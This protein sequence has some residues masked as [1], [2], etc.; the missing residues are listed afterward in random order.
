MKN[1]LSF[2]S[3][4]L[5]SIMV[6]VICVGLAAG[7]GLYIREA[8]SWKCPC[9]V[10]ALAVRAVGVTLT[11]Y[12]QTWIAWTYVLL[13]NN[14]AAL[15]A[16]ISGNTQ[17]NQESDSYETMVAARTR[18]Q[19]MSFRQTLR[20][21]ESPDFK[22]QA[23]LANVSGGSAATMRATGQALAEEDIDWIR[24]LTTL[25]AG[26]TANNNANTLRY[27]TE[28]YC[29]Q[30]QKDQGLCET[31]DP[32]LA[33]ANRKAEIMMQQNVLSEDFRNASVDF[34]RTLIGPNPQIDLGR[35]TTPQ[36]V[37]QANNRD[38]RDARMG[39]VLLTCR[40][41]ISMREEIDDS[42]MAEWAETMRKLI[43]GIEDGVPD[44]LA[45]LSSDTQGTSYY[46]I[47]QFASQYR[48][49]NSEWYEHLAT[50]P[51]PVSVYKTIAA[52]RATKLHLK[53]Q[54]FRIH[55]MNAALIATIQGAE[56]NVYYDQKSGAISEATF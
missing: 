32:K 7:M 22:L 44:A 20:H 51:D 24:G 56:S 8:R 13:A 2:K 46:E 10:S 39:L 35:I 45:G 47:L 16:Q 14:F 25:S 23:T 31:V 38:T 5:P 6:I 19:S 40:H 15:N 37:I 55:E 36:G 49:S 42:D 53:F 50:M 54:R 33:G 48:A 29:T 41:L 12:T 30:I 28:T 21:T 26:S 3:R 27:N 34:C 18:S 52:I 43:Y 1:P 9:G 17:V 4:A 11:T